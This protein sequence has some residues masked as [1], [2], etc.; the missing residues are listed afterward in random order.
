ML[1]WRFSGTMT[2]VA[3]LESPFARNPAAATYYEDGAA[4][5]DDW[6]LGV[7]QYAERDRPDCHAEVSRLVELVAAL[8][9]A[10]TLDVACGS[11]FLSQHVQGG[12]VGLDQSPS[13]LELARTRIGRGMAVRGDALRLPFADGSFDRVLT[14][15]FYGHLG[16]EERAAFLTETSRVARELV[17]VDSALVQGTLPEL[18]EERHLDD[19]THHRIYKRYFT[20]DQLAHEIGGESVMSGRWFV[21]ARAALTARD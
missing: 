20:P 19:G 9:P 17:V 10:R 16:P 14:G 8:A 11:G 4:E 7:G 15:H 21:V 3:A 13:M 18:W 2:G 5:Y 1:S 6:Y 12:V